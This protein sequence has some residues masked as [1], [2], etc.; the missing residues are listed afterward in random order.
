MKKMTSL[1]LIC[2]LAASCSKYETTSSNHSSSDTETTQSSVIP[3]EERLTIEKMYDGY[4]KEYGGDVSIEIIDGLVYAKRLLEPGNAY[5]FELIDEYTVCC[6]AYMKIDGNYFA[7]PQNFDGN[8]SLIKDRDY[9]LKFYVRRKRELIN[10]DLGPTGLYCYD[11][12]SIGDELLT[13]N[14]DDLLPS[15]S[16]RDAYSYKCKK[17]EEIITVN[18]NSVTY[19]FH[20]TGT[21]Y[22]NESKKHTLS[23]YAIGMDTIYVNPMKNTFIEGEEVDVARYTVYDAD[24]HI[25]CNGFIL[26]V[27]K[28]YYSDDDRLIHSKIPFPPFDITLY[29]R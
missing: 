20:I 13:F 5:G 7:T 1:A 4:Q 16:L 26:R 14:G 3:E 2:I 23:A 11:V 15:N 22:D 28:E 29:C 18:F 24:Y 12:Y 25:M 10:H 21:P 8:L 6:A 27:A 9:T 17:E 19:E